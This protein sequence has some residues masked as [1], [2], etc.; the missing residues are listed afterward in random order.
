MNAASKGINIVKTGEKTKFISLSHKK[1]VCFLFS[2][3]SV[4]NNVKFKILPYTVALKI[5]PV[6]KGL[7]RDKETALVFDHQN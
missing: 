7:L 1:N 6:T 2:N 5:H 3:V 4:A